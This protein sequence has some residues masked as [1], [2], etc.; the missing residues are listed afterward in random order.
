MAFQR[1]SPH[2]G[3]CNPGIQRYRLHA[4]NHHAPCSTKGRIEVVKLL[5]AAGANKECRNK[6]RA[7]PQQRTVL[8]HADCAIAV[9]SL[10]GL[11]PTFAPRGTCSRSRR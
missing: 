11:M 5:L 2:T 7:V 3:T 4:Y 1:S 6:V 10:P 8:F 9:C